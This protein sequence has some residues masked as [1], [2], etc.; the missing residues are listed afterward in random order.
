MGLTEKGR[1]FADEVVIQFYHPD[2]IPFP[3]SAYA[4]GELSPYRS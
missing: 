2:Y 3:K 4:D 1:F